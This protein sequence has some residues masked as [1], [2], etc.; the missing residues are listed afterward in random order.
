LNPRPGSLSV[1]ALHGLADSASTVNR[2]VF[3]VRRCMA[4]PGVRSRFPRAPK[5]PVTILGGRQALAWY[6]VLAYDRSRLDAEGIESATERVHTA[7]RTERA[8]GRRVVLMGFSQGGALALH[9]GLGLAS[10]VAGI[11][12]LAAGVPF[13]DR[14]ATAGP[15]APRLFF[16]HGRFDRVVPH[17]LGRESHRLLQEHG[18]AS[19]WHSYWCG[20]VLGRRILADVR[21]WLGREFLVTPEGY[22]ARTNEAG[23]AGRDP[24]GVTIPRRSQGSRGERTRPWEPATLSG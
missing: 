11:V 10:E 16:G 4:T 2:M 21:G 23:A 1:I 3:E 15:R 20:H 17:A 12:A 13:L 19:E 24:A 6:D 9:A 22:P 14:L 18:Y 8:A 5:R 7:V